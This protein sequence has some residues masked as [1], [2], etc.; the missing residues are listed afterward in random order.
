MYNRVILRS[1]EGIRHITR[2]IWESCGRCSAASEKTFLPRQPK[3]GLYR[4]RA[5][6]LRKGFWRE[7]HNYWL[8]HLWHSTR[9][10]RTLSAGAPCPLTLGSDGGDFHVIWTLNVLCLSSVLLSMKVGYSGA[11]QQQ[12]PI[13]RPLVVFTLD[14]NQSCFYR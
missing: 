1:Y 6:Q 9:E 5:R 8:Y 14:I 12:Q 2:K 13:K 3:S 7:P 10:Y 11:Y 4:D